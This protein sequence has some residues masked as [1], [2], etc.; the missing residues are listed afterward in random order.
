MRV[1]SDPLNQLGL[2]LGHLARVGISSQC[3]FLVRIRI[4]TDWHNVYLNVCVLLDVT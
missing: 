2:C 4:V 1:S 3:G